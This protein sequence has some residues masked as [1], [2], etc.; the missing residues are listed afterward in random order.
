MDDPRRKR[1]AVQIS[2]DMHDFNVIV[3]RIISYI[4]PINTQV[5]NNCRR[6]ERQRGVSTEIKIKKIL[7]NLRFSF[8]RHR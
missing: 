3:E 2:N 7:L 8:L 4:C 6:K 5:R 1:I